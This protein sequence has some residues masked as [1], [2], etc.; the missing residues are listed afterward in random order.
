MGTEADQDGSKPETRR[1]LTA[2]DYFLQRRNF[3]DCYKYATRAHDADPTNPAAT[4]ILSTAAVL[5]ASKIS[6]TQHDYYAIL[7]LPYFDSDVS[8]I[9]SSFETLTSILDPNTNLCPFSSEAFD[10]AVKAWSVLSN[11]VEKAKFDAELRTY[12]GGGDGCTPG[13]GGDTFWTMCPYCYHVYEYDRVFEDCCLRC[14]N[15][16]CRRVLHAVAIAGPPPPDVVAK[17]QYCC[18]GFMPF[19]VHTSNGEAIGEKMWVPFAPSHHDFRIMVMAKRR[20]LKVKTKEIS[21]GKHLKMQVEN[22]W[23]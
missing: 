13:S 12:M 15:E 7:N 3:V 20:K 11:S 19:A 10:L 2:A 9:G 6:A 23:G 22:L 8:R 4:R 21:M 1:L 16:R 14:A 18:P 17:G 5:S